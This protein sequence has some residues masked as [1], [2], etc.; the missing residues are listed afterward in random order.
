[1]HTFQLSACVLQQGK[2]GFSMQ[3]SI[4]NILGN[5]ET[6]L[7]LK[8]FFDNTAMLARRLFL[9]RQVVVQNTSNGNEQLTPLA[10]LRCHFVGSC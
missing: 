3:T 8:Q 2:Q 5:H 1:M 7:H 10:D 9:Y 6:G 4:I